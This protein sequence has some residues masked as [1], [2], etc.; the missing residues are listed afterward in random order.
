MK[1]DFDLD[2]AL[3]ES[4]HDM[5]APPCVQALLA[6]TLALMT[7][8]A[9]PATGA[10]VDV[11]MQRQLMARKIVHNLQ[12]LQQHAAIPQALRQVMA[13]AQRRWLAVAATHVNLG[14]P[15]LALWH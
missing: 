8:W 5:P 9:D 15:S 4:H 11:A 12:A 1:P 6:G 13:Q 3:D 7:T 14:Q 2:G 10:R